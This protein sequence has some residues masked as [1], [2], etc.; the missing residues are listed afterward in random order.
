MIRA[1]IFDCFGVV[2]TDA[3]QEV[4][5]ALAEHDSAAADKVTDI[6]AANNRGLVPPSESNAKIAHVLGM[7][8]DAYRALIAARE[9]RNSALLE[10][11][12]GLRKTYKTAMLSNIAGSSLERRFPDDE[13]GVYFDEVVASAD[14]GYMKPEPEAYRFVAERLGVTPNECVFID[15]REVFCVAA[16]S[17]GMQAILYTNF[18]QFRQG[19]ESTL[20][21]SE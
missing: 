6:V 10:Y 8:A 12:Q 4:R 16:T 3:L 15:D 13:L 1:I 11:I 18:A 20:A 14:I 19:L 17:V 21:N 9:V 7:D 2:L 5:T